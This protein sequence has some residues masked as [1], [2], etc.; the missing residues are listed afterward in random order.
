MQ[1]GPNVVTVAVPPLTTLMLIVL[2][3]HDSPPQFDASDQL[4]DNG[5]HVYAA[6]LASPAR[7]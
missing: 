6:Q 2:S 1:A 5:C 3:R 4:P 7:K